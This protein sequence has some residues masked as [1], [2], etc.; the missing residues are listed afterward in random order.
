MVTRTY[1]KH[2]KVS[3][4]ANRRIWTKIQKRKNIER[5]K[6]WAQAE[7]SSAA[8]LSVVNIKCRPVDSSLCL[9]SSDTS[10]LP[11]TSPHDED[12]LLPAGLLST[13]SWGDKKH[14]HILTIVPDSVQETAVLSDNLSSTKYCV[15]QTWTFHREEPSFWKLTVEYLLKICSCCS[16]PSFM[17]QPI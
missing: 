3:N 8:C 7:R 16:V 4:P 15:S 5:N 2:K 10:C 17:L 11:V 13:G 14:P 1:R 12:N 9:S 6:Q